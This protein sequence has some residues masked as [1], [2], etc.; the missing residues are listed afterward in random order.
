MIRF[1]KHQLQGILSYQY[2]KHTCRGMGSRAIPGNPPGKVL[3]INEQ[4]D[5]PNIDVERLQSTLQSIRKYIGYDTYDVA[6]VLIDDKE[7]KAINFE[8]RRQKRPTDIL[9][10][11][12]H[13]AIEPGTLC[14]PLFNVPD[15]YS[16]GEI[17]VDVP[18]VMRQCLADKEYYEAES[19]QEDDDDDSNN[20]NKETDKNESEEDLNGE[21]DNDDDDEEE[22]EERGVSGAMARIYDPETRI[23]MLLVHGMLHLVGYDHETEEDYQLMVAK[24]EELLEKLGMMPPN[25]NDESLS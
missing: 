22:E 5:L 2:L 25:R 17:L 19:E 9:S 1:G 14:E 6:L 10:F 24:E 15:Y 16:L 21:D 8:S 11:S 4:E 12:F 20:N 13:P 23:N 3:V 7:M 18:Y